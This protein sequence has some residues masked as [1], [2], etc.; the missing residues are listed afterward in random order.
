MPDPVIEPVSPE[1]GKEDQPALDPKAVA[2]ELL[3]S[4]LNK[5]GEQKYSSTEK[6]LESIPHKDKHIEKIEQDNKN[7]GQAFDELNAKFKE[8]DS[9]V[10]ITNIIGDKLKEAQS[11]SQVEQPSGAALDE[12]QLSKLVSSLIEDSNTQKTQQANMETFVEAIAAE[13]DK[14]KEYISN[15]AASLSIGE[16]TF[17]GLIAQNP[18]AALQ[19]CGI[20]VTKPINKVQSSINTQGLKTAPHVED[21]LPTFQSKKN[22]RVAAAEKLYAEISARNQ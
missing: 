20:D 15:K 12:Q 3:K 14:P 5:D 21:D 18:K 8:L 1:A 10:D 7:L 11:S 6:A 19:L 17:K 13:T 22:P 4:I 9:K 16:N 2:E